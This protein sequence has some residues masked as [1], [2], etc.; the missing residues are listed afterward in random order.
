[1][2]IAHRGDQDHG[3]E[4]LLQL[5]EIGR[6]L[7]VALHL[8]NDRHLLP[9]PHQRLAQRPGPLARVDRRRC[10]QQRV[11]LR[12]RGRVALSGPA[13]AAQDDPDHAF[14]Q[15]RLGL[16]QL[17]PARPRQGHDFRIPQGIDRAGVRLV[18]DDAVA[19]QVRSAEEQRHLADRLTRAD[20]P[21]ELAVALGGPE[22]F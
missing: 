7:L 3:V 5:V 4:S 15:F 1:L 9:E 11:D 20:M 16:H 6:R 10:G 12:H 13:E 22:G 2:V 19:V 18:F 21:Y 8:V 14:Q 17:V